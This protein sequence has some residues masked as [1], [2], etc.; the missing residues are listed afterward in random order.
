MTFGLLCAIIS[1]PEQI[2][3]QLAAAVTYQAFLEHAPQI[4]PDAASI[5]GIIHGMRV[6][7][8]EEPLMQTIC[9]LEK[10][11]DDMVRV[12][13]TIGRGSKRDQKERK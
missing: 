6:E 8:I 7:K 13:L 4:H 12:S 10:L 3:Q 5:T 2:A 11:V 1:S 9:R